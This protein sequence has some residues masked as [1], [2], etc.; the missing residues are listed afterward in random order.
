VGGEFCHQAKHRLVLGTEKEQAYYMFNVLGIKQSESYSI[1]NITDLGPEISFG[2]KGNSQKIYDFKTG[3]KIFLPATFIKNWYENISVDFEYV[4][5]LVI[6]FPNIKTEKII[7]LLPTPTTVSLP[8]DYF[9]E[10]EVVFFKR[11]CLK[12]TEIRLNI[13]TEF[14]IKKNI[15]APSEISLLK[16]SLQVVN[17]YLQQKIIIEL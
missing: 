15:V 10:N 12:D 3:N 13:E 16:E 9:F 2:I 14:S 5:D 11:K 7:Y 4:N 1:E 6:D 8:S 17:K